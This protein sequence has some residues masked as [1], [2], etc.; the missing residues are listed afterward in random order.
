MFCLSC[1]LGKNHRLVVS[2]S[3][4]KNKASMDLIFCDVWD[5]PKFDG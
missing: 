3:M 2:P 4:S 1:Q 5:Q